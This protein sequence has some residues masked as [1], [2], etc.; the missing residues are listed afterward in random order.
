MGVSREAVQW[1]GIRGLNKGMFMR[2]KR[3]KKL[4]RD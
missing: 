2:I 1:R 3:G 4:E